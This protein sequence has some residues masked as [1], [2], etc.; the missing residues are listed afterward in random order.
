MFFLYKFGC[1]SGLTE[2]RYVDQCTSVRT[3]KLEERGKGVDI[4]L[5]NQIQIENSL[6]S[7]PFA[8]QGDSGS[9]VFAFD[10][11]DTRAVG[12]FEGK[13][14]HYYFATPIEDA[15]S[16]ISKG[17]S[18]FKSQQRPSGE[19]M[20]VEMNHGQLTMIQMPFVPQCDPESYVDQSAVD[21]LEQKTCDLEKN[22]VHHVEHSLDT[23]KEEITSL[24][25]NIEQSNTQMRE[26]F[27]EKFKTLENLLSNRQTT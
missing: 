19:E 24:K 21:K 26:Y 11:G 20:E 13:M 4:T 17:L 15:Y 6:H 2:G 23:V 1:S 12:I 14:D 10:R 22:I 25:V 7:K 16:V 9:L 27:D 3:N 8:T 18:Q 5:F